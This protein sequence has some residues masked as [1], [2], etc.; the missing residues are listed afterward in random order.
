MLN[1]IAYFD[2]AKAILIF[3]VIAGHMLSKFLHNDHV[4]DSIYLFIYLF[5]M[6]AFILISGYFSKKVYQPGYISKLVKKLIIPY[7]LLQ[8]LYSLYYYFIFNDSISFSFFIPRWALWFLLSLI[9]WNLLL[10]GFGK[11]KYGIPIAIGISLI[12]GYDSYVGGFLSLSRT[13][14]F[15]PFF[16]VGYYLQKHHF[17]ALKSRLNVI[18]GAIVGII[19]V[20]V[21][22]FYV[23]IEFSQWLHGKKSY[24]DMSSSF[25]QFGWAIR[26]VA[27]LGMAAATYMFLTLVPRKQLFFTSIGQNTMAIY[28]LHMALIRIF[29]ASP[30][31]V[32]IEEEHQYWII[33][34]ID[35]VIVYILSRP[36]V[37]NFVFKIF[38]VK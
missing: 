19:L 10:Y 23:P 36:P 14:F 34:I 25:L 32:F 3:L 27:Y 20:V 12:I 24:E 21:I 26:L 35:V 31:K 7:A 8:V 4:I 37:V 30:L 17:E 18:I 16:L 5:H 1:R 28:L 2:N 38:K 33:F 11:I 9:F 22:Y 6:P 13:F 29:E 15:F